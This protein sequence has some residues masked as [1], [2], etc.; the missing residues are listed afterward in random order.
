MTINDLESQINFKINTKI[1]QLEN[2]VSSLN[3]NYQSL[4]KKHSQLRKQAD[5]HKKNDSKN[6]CNTSLNLNTRNFPRLLNL[7][8]EALETSP[9]IHER[10]RKKKFDNF[11]PPRIQFRKEVK[12][13]DHLSKLKF[14]NFQLK[15]SLEG[16]NKKMESLLKENDELKTETNRNAYSLKVIIIFNL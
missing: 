10:E 13:D 12:A 14:E 7:S 15:N 8:V 2:T 9:D 11:I 5:L 1:E 6:I 4:M 3:A 16:V